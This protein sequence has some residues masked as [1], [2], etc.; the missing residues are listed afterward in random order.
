MDNESV[1]SEVQHGNNGDQGV[2]HLKYI[3]PI[4]LDQVDKDK[5][6]WL[7]EKLKTQSYAFDDNTKE[8]A[9]RFLL[10]LFAPGTEHFFIQDKGYASAV[11]ICPRTSCLIHFALWEPL[12]GAGVYNAIRELLG[13]LFERY[14]LNRITAAIPVYNKQVNRLAIMLGFRFEGELRQAILY[15]GKYHNITMYGLLAEEFNRREVAHA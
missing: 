14:Q 1:V 6:Q 4:V 3:E 15:E 5:I 2:R 10:S 13:Y 8:D 11:G 12:E 9:H 7:W